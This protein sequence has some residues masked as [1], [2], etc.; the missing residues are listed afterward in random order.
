M[1]VLGALWS[2]LASL[3]SPT[4]VLVT[5]RQVETLGPPPTDAHVPEG[6]SPTVQLQ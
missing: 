2:D 4:F 5:D 1:E 3:E 6:L